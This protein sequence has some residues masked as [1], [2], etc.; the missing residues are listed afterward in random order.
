MAVGYS[1][2]VAAAMAALVLAI[3]AT[4]LSVYLVLAMTSPRGAASHADSFGGALFAFL[5]C[6]V[7]AG[8]IDSPPRILASIVGALVMAWLLRDYVRAVCWAICASRS[9]GAVE[10]QDRWAPAAEPQGVGRRSSRDD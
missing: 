3:T 4:A 8:I 9:A 5:V 10:C 7:F 1:S 6:N 2:L